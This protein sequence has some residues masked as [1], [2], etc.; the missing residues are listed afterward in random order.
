M[1]GLAPVRAVRI[2]RAREKIAGG[3]VASAHQMDLCEG[4]EDRAARFMEL[5]RASHVERAVQRVLRAAQIAQAHTDLSERRER[6]GQAV[7]P[8]VLLV[9]RDA[10][11]GERERLLVTVLQH[12]DARL[13]PAYRRQHV[14][15]MDERGEPL[16]LAQRHHR[17]VVSPQLGQRHTREGVDEREMAAIAGG[18]QR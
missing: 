3:V 5:N 6:D 15:G 13:V 8:A 14:V 11:L 2:A 17:L 10:S 1:A 12:R 18:V 4:V 16:G 9:K 7:A